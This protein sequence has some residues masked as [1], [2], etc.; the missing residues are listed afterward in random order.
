MPVAPRQSR[1]PL[2]LVLGAL[3]VGYLLSLPWQRQQWARV[4]A[5]RAE[6]RSQQARLETL[7]QLKSRGTET[8]RAL[9]QS[10]ASQ[11]TLFQATEAA[12]AQ[13]NRPRA[14]QLLGQLEETLGSE[15]DLAACIAL[16]QLYQRLG[17]LDKGLAYAERA[18]ALD[19]DSPAALVPL[20]FLEAHLGWL[21]RAWPHLKKAQ[22]LDPEAP[23]I[24]SAQALLH[25]QMG[26]YDDVEKSLLAALKQ[27]PEDWA[28]RILLA[29]NQLA[30][31]RYTAALAT[32]AEAE[33]VAPGQPGILSAQVEAQFGQAQ[34]TAQG[35]PKLLE[36][37]LERA[38]NY[39]A[40]SPDSA[41]DAHYW[42]GKI[43]LAQK[44]EREALAEWE[45]A[46]TPDTDNQMLLIG[47]GQ[48]LVRLGE[49][50]R[51]EQLLTRSRTLR[52]SGEE[53]TRWIA[54][55]RDDFEN[56]ELHRKFARW[57][58]KEGRLPRAIIEWDQ[59]LRLVP[60]DPEA[61]KNRTLCLSQRQ[62]S[63]H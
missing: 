27:S 18:V 45:R 58:Q 29:R 10:P 28:T 51:G 15:P 56:S 9:E 21:E 59:T 63:A 4:E 1:R 48:L 61:L 54:N 42:I 57:C 53:Y 17:W 14:T 36:T 19:P 38:R 31:K 46:Y 60:N 62:G 44:K 32:L 43:L 12:L 2:F 5:L 55:T 50:G 13:N 37:A 30:Q 49:R 35:D 47:M 40:L 6:T 7:Q 34:Q 25:D 33:K 39:A 3:G 11:E 8:E 22:T 20:T 16:S 23:G 41:R 52:Q 24:H 26:A